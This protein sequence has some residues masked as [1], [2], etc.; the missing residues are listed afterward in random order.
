MYNFIILTQYNSRRLQSKADF[1]IIQV[2]PER[3]SKCRLHNTLPKANWIRL[4]LG[5]IL[6][7]HSIRRKF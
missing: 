7:E 5:T 1:Q 6:S 3:N 4:Y 2:I